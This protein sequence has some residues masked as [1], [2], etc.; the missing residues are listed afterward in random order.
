MSEPPERKPY[1]WPMIFLTAFTLGALL[2]ALWM[3]KVIRQT[4]ANRD[5]NFFVPFS[6][7]PPVQPRPATNPPPARTNSA[8]ATPFV[9]A[10]GARIKWYEVTLIFRI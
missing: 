5:N 6:N 3:S 7:P 2:W 1:L 9:L 8:L 4:R 10:A